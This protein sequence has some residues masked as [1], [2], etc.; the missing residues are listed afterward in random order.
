MSTRC[1]QVQIK[2][3]LYNINVYNEQITSKRVGNN[4][5]IHM[6]KQFDIMYFLFTLEL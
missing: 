4:T 5:T 3:I 2:L 6:F 1:N